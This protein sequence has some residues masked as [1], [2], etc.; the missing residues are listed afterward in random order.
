MSEISD[1]AAKDN[2]DYLQRE[3]ENLVDKLNHMKGY[4][5]M[6]IHTINKAKVA[7]LC[8]AHRRTYKFEP[9]DSRYDPNQVLC[10]VSIDVDT[11]ANVWSSNDPMTKDDEKS[12]SMG[13]L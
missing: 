5:H 7:D 4:I 8:L 2:Q 12:W 9:T 13:S 10:Y 1:I 11:R 3:L 6:T